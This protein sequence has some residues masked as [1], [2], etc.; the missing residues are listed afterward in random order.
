MSRTT[1]YLPEYCDAVVE[2]GRKG[3]SRIQMAAKFHCDRKTL[4]NWAK[5]NPEFKT[6]LDWSRD[7]AQAWW[8]DAG[9]EGIWTEQGGRQFNANAYR[10]QVL[11]RF[12]DDWRDKQ[13][14]K[15]EGGVTIKISSTDERL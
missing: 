6:A 14:H 7:L 12:P 4:D 10:L 2:M 15:H 13:D 9:Q 11:N 5:A 3:K 8:E 1:T